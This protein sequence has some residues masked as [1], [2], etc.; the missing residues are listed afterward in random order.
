VCNLPKLL[1]VAPSAYTL[2]GLATWLD[3]LLPGLQIT[4][5]DVTLG[6]VS[7]PR[8]HTPRSYLQAHPY[9]KSIAIHCN[10]GTRFGRIQAVRT[11]LRKLQPD[12][13]LT[14][15]IPDA[16]VATAIER[17]ESG[18]KVRAVMSCHGIQ[19]DLFVDMR[20][21]RQMLD[22][23]VCTNQLASRLT[24]VIGGMDGKRIQHAPYGTEVPSQLP[25]RFENKEFTIAFAGRLEQPQKRIHDLTQI[26]SRL[27]FSG[28]RYR[29]LIAGTGPEESS[30]RKELEEQ[31]LI[32]D[33]EF[34]G[35]VDPSRLNE[36]LYRR[37]DVLLVTSSWETG[38]IVIW[39]AMAA[40]VPVVTSRYVGSGREALLWHQQ[41]CL[42]FNAGDIEGAARELNALYQE[43]GV[44]E[45]IRFH[46]FV[47]VS[48]KLTWDLSAQ[49]WDRILRQV[50]E[51]DPVCSALPDYADISTDVGRLDRFLG[52]SAAESIRKLL[53]RLPP[54]TGPGGE[55][56]H[57]ISGNLMSDTEFWE[58]TQKLDVRAHVSERPIDSKLII[59]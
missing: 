43:K 34:L 5:W 33:F 42:M 48:E 30:F 7:G 12:I 51:S 17:R 45:K 52:P 1:V 26:A 21:L 35:F 3:Y 37:A 16:V 40:G 14:V 46:A 38:P 41:N 59:S 18:L 29:F 25:A 32:S 28:V 24:E 20:Q 22:H 57:T 49:N 8:Y 9:D 47:T 10:S 44:G 53:Q 54:D 15:N 39:E 23:V 6:L 50:L 4:G 27:K 11:A 55:W 31:G 36:K 2:G 58:K 56:P 13:V 19:Q